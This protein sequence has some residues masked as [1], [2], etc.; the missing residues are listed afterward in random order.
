MAQPP[1]VPRR[2]AGNPDGKGSIGLLAD[3]DRSEP[4]D[5]VAKPERQVL[6]EFF[7]SMLVLSA[8]FRYQ[9][10][11]GN[12]NYLY[13]IDGEW[14]LSLIAPEEWSDERRDGFVGTCVLQRDMTWTIVPSDRIGKSNAVSDALGNFFDGFAMMMNTDLTLEETLPSYVAR[15][16]YYQRL[17]ASALSR[18]MRVTLALGEQT[19]RSCRQ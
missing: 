2:P 6:A 9:P 10:V 7:T 19:A 11:A 14:S 15:L 18:S 8:S 5:V 1:L 4:R 17:L 13:W 16:P 3:W 12:Q